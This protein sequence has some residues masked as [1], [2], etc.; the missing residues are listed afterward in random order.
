MALAPYSSV[1][2]EEVVSEESATLL[3]HTFRQL[4]RIDSLSEQIGF[5]EERLGTC[6]SSQKRV[7]ERLDRKRC[8]QCSMRKKS[9]G[10][11]DKNRKEKSQ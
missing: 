6:K 1:F 9:K 3:S 4:D 8:I 7:R 10:K 2:P 11:T 5:L